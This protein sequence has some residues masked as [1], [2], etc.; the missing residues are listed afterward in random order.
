[1]RQLNGRHREQLQGSLILFTASPPPM[2]TLPGTA[3]ARLRGR[4]NAFP[5]SRPCTLVYHHVLRVHR[6]PARRSNV[7]A[8]RH[9]VAA[10]RATDGGAIK[11]V[12]AANGAAG[13]MGSW[14]QPQRIGGI[15]SAQPGSCAARAFVGYAARA[16]AQPGSGLQAG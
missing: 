6:R 1:V 16:A 9:I 12:C 2:G 11:H 13:S 10:S 8:R 7:H 5:R 14:A 4:H 3:R 15:V